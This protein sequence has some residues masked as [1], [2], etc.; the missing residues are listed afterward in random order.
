ML[1]PKEI[2]AAY[3][4]LAAYAAGERNLETLAGALPTALEEW[5]PEIKLLWNKL[6]QVDCSQL[7]SDLFKRYSFSENVSELQGQIDDRVREILRLRTFATQKSET[8]QDLGDRHDVTKER[9]RQLEEKFVQKLKDIRNE[10]M[11]G[12]ITRRAKALHKHLGSAVPR[13]DTTIEKGLDWA[14]EDLS[15]NDNID[16]PFIRALML[17]LAGPY[18]L[19]K[20]WW[21]TERK[22]PKLT[23]EGLLKCQ[24]DRGLISH[25]EIAETLNSFELKAEYHERW[26]E[27]LPGFFPVEKGLLYSRRSQLNKVY[28]LLRYYD[29]P[30]G[31]KQLAEEVGGCPEK[32]LRQRLIIDSRFT[33]INKQCEF[34][35]AGTTDHKKYTD[36]VNMIVQEIEACGGEASSADLIEKISNAYG[37]K[38][39]SVYA[40]LRTKKFAIDKNGMASVRDISDGISIPTDISKSASCYRSNGEVWVWRL[41]INKDMLRGSGIFVPNAFAQ[42]LGCE[43]G[44]KIRSVT[45][46]GSL[47]VS[48]RLATI[49][50]ATIGSLRNVIQFYKAQ[51]GDYIFI[52]AT[53]PIIT[54][55]LLSQSSLRE[56]R[57][58]LIRLS[59][60]LGCG[61]QGNDAQAKTY[62][63]RTLGIYTPSD[64][65]SLAE[66]VRLLQARKE[67]ELAKLITL[68]PV[69]AT[70]LLPT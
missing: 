34:V 55:E 25:A 14:C 60:L 44:R 28:A 39:N 30:M 52:K 5:P 19:S 61:S 9:I 65:E 2:E 6:G 1:V 37:V 32:S 54:F 51:P 70:N 36:I 69:P 40:Y 35:I 21:L 41:L 11:F 16:L 17:W 48:W 23:L 68:Q 12:V 43:P 26:V 67:T 31:V 66:A 20:N 47:V 3:Q 33:R 50:G 42:I 45:A 24:D 38:E 13:G 18:K 7:E 15:G 64:Q 46:F 59:L 62:I 4:M 22:L 10:E 63:Y 49:G 56:A 57:T 58:D 27:G 29:K 53:K 8:L